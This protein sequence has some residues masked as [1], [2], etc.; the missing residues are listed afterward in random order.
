M[1]LIDSNKRLIQYEKGESKGD[2]FLRFKD[3]ASV[4]K[5]VLKK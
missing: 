4:R 1:G 3:K 2:I 5:V